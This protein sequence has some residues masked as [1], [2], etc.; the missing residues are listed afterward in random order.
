MSR[1]KS[2][3]A[4]GS[5]PAPAPTRG[6]L[7]V[8]E[9][10]ADRHRIEPSGAMNVPG[11]VFA[12]RPLLPDIED[13]LR[14]VANVATL[15]GIVRASFAMP[16]VHWGYGFPI[17][18]VAATDPA[19][20]GVV[21]P[22]GVGFDISCGVRLLTAP[23]QE[24][25]LRPRL[26]AL[27]TALSRLVP[28]GAG[29]G[30]VWDAT[31]ADLRGILLRGSVYAV[32]QGYGTDRDLARCED[33]GAVDDADPAA[34]SERALA[35]GAVQVGSLGSG[36]HFLELQVV[37]RILDPIAAGF[38]LV[39]GQVAVMIH[40]GSR[41]LGHQ[42][43]SDYVRLMQD[44]M[45]RYGI[46]VPDAQLACAPVESREGHAYLT[47]M[48]A[49]ANFA[50]ANRQLLTHAVRQAFREVTGTGALDLLYDVSHN[51]AKLEQHEVRPWGGA[52]G[53]TQVVCVH[54]KGA[55]R[56]LPPGHAALPEDL[57]PLGQPVLVPGSMGTASWVLAGEE[58]NP[59]FDSACH[60]AGRVMSRTAATKR[61]SGNQ[62]K[63]QLAA[64]GI[65]VRAS[66]TRGLAEEA[67]FAYKD[68]DE[69]VAVCGREGLARPVARLRPI[70]VVKG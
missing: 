19:N 8:T 9:E 47:A 27:M 16:D 5:G 2:S 12:S 52:G 44:A 28:R 63:E 53:G 18:G 6:P 17:G 15:P 69:V 70:G 40:C 33:G 51:L 49:A 1:A 3:R 11:I 57:R 42:I 62:L 7:V 66:S 25:E 43:C 26:S 50:R 31:P 56:A 67:P 46:R 22:G 61:V 10:T 39:E 59:A 20:G 65:E 35:R 60:G 68:V 54:R 36:N 29:P 38:W 58:G 24:A 37:D 32:A 4:A 30:G 41:G 23:F 48:A 55:T 34:L 14:Q 64:Q 45:P 21:S 13:A